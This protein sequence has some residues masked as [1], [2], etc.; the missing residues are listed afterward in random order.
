[1]RP[2]VEIT[3]ATVAL[4]LHGN[5]KG[6]ALKLY[7][8]GDERKVAARAD[9]AADYAKAGKILPD[10][11]KW[12]LLDGETVLGVGGVE[13]LGSG[14]WGA[15]AYLADMSVRQW[16]FAALMA[17]SVLAFVRQTF[18]ASEIHAQSAAVAGAGRLLEKLG[19]MAVDDDLGFYLML[20]D[21]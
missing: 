13:P 19:F 12:T 15:W 4:F 6:L 3:P 18:W 20:G 11:P 2:V 8:P 17:R 1:M 16:G 9:F 14:C 21:D 10:G 7:R 5:V